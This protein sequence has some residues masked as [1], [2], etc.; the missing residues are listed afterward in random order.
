MSDWYMATQLRNFRDGIRGGH[1]QDMSGA[2]MA[3][4]ARM[5]RDDRSIEDVLAYIDSLEI[6]TKT[7]SAER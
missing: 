1:P 5:L 6:R 3:L 2:Q 7:A 4:F